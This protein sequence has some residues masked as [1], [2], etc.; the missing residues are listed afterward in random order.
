MLQTLTSTQ[1]H[2]T[3]PPNNWSKLYSDFAGEIHRPKPQRGNFSHILYHIPKLFFPLF[4]DSKHAV[5]KGGKIIHI[6][7]YS[8]LA[9][10]IN[11]K[12]LKQPQKGLATESNLVILIIELHGSHFYFCQFCIYPLHACIDSPVNLGILLD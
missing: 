1:I 8:L 11:N 12:H 4:L 6:V 3:N 2:H 9:I 7:K 10:N 5:L